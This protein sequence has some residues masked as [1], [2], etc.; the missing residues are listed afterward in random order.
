MKSGSP[1]G[2]GPFGSL[3]DHSTSSLPISVVRSASEEPPEDCVQ[4]EP[5]GA[6]AE[7]NQRSQEKGERGGADKFVR[8]APD[9][10][11]GVAVPKPVSYRHRNRHWDRRE[12]RREAGYDQNAAE[13]FGTTHNP[14]VDFRERDSQ[15][16]KKAYRRCDVLQF[17][18]PNFKQLPEKIDSDEK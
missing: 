10:Q 6:E 16:S 14:R 1:P 8:M 18:E 3:T 5:T 12:A 2:G 7:D 15:F 17:G 11:D 9:I 13:T 4:R